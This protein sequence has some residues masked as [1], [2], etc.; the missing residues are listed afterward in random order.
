M[1]LALINEIKPESF[2]FLFR[3]QFSDQTKAQSLRWQPEICLL[4]NYVNTLSF[5]YLRQTQQEKKYSSH[6]SAA[7]ATV[8]GN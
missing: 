3:V 4:Q 2:D 7:M 5:S 6:G 1:K 8:Q